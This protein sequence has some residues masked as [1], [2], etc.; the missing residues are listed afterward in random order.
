MRFLSVFLLALK[1]A[2][3]SQTLEFIFPSGLVAFPVLILLAL[4]VLGRLKHDGS[5][6]L[7]IFV[8]QN[9]AVVHEAWKLEHVIDGGLEVGASFGVIGLGPA[10]SVSKGVDRVD[11]GG[12]FESLVPR[13]IDCCVSAYVFADCVLRTIRLIEHNSVALVVWLN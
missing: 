13:F 9:V 10:D 11:E 4:I 12:V 1:G 2:F 5:H 8:I 3:L 6:H 7:I